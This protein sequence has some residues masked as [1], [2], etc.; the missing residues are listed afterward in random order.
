[1]KYVTEE[2]RRGSEESRAQRDTL[3]RDTANRRS[4]GSLAPTL[5]RFSATGLADRDA[6]R[7]YCFL[8]LVQVAVRG[9]QQLRRR[10]SVFRVHADADADV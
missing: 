5:N 2:T 6:L 9:F 1:M 10:A 4:L 3:L 8:A 7:V